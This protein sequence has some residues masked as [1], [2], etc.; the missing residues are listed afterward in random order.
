M[1]TLFLDE[2][3]GERFCRQHN[4]YVFHDIIVWFWNLFEI[5]NSGMVFAILMLNK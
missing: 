4:N 3:T 2:K 5:L 1:E